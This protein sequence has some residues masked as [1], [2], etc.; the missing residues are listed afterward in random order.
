MED[1]SQEH[2]EMMT[3]LFE[4]VWSKGN[5]DAADEFY[6]PGDHLE[7]LKHVARSLYAAFPDYHVTI[8]DMVVEGNKIAVYWTGRGTHQGEW[9]GIA[10]TGRQ[11][12]V[13]GIDI[14]YVSEGKIVS[15]EGV[16]DMSGMMRQLS[17][18]T[19]PSVG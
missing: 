6:A 18:E 13:E 11:I 10:A 17:V 19:Q 15:E 12:S 3:R 4:E 1:R 9:Q 8:N 5:A 2:R 16:I 14:E 7:G